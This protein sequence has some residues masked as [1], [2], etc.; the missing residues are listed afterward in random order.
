MIRL[1]H[2]KQLVLEYVERQIARTGEAP[3]MA[4]ICK[5]FDWRSPASA[6]QILTTLESEGRI[7]RTRRWRGIEI[8]RERVT[9]MVGWLDR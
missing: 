7:K 5:H 2:S 4:E 8:V 9:P 6:H 3:T 1:R